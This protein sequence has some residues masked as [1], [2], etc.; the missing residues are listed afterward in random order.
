MMP[1]QN[2]R[3]TAIAADTMVFTH[4]GLTHTFPVWSCGQHWYSFSESKHCR[5]V[6]SGMVKTFR[7]P[8]LKQK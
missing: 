8:D 4:S 2:V 3:T 1:L 5:L 6:C 7:C